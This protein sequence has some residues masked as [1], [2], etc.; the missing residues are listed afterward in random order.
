[1]KGQT[2]AILMIGNNSMLSRSNKQKVNTRNSTE[3]ELIA[4]DDTLP[5]VQ[6]TKKFMQDQG[7]D[8]D[9]IL[10][11]DNKSSILLMKNGRLSSGKRMKHHDI[12]YFYVKELLDRGVVKIEHC[13]T[14]DMVADFFTKPLLGKRFKIMRGLIVN[15]NISF[16]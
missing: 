7:Y 10:K 14:E 3:T 1:M 12:R 15:Q 16:T 2:G 4:V 13:S 5:I 9:T 11:E 6:W 8:L